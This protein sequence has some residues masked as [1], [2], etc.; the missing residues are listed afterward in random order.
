MKGVLFLLLAMWAAQAQAACRQ[1]LALGL[2]V[3]GSVNAQE[4]RLQ[5]DG[6]AGALENPEVVAA[7]L[8]MPDAPVRLTVFEWSG[9]YAQRTLQDWVEVTDRAVVAEVATR[10]RGLA[11]AE[12]DPSTAIGSAKAHGARLLAG[13]SDCWRQVLDLSGDGKN[14]TGPRPQDV[15][16]LGVTINALIIG[17]PAAPGQP[18]PG[19]GELVAYFRA[20]VIEGEQAFV[21][22]AL[23]FDDFEAAMVRKLKRELQ[24]M[25]LSRR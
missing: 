25:I 5:L 15:R 8:E 14:N 13:Q 16:P 12:L 11:R 2:D 19:L 23:G 4:Y 10:L 6:L 3:S 22:T 1:A 9:E 20:Y 17:S 7:L 24:V 18:A 21:E